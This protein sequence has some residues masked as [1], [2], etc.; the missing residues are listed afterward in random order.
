MADEPSTVLG[1]ERDILEQALELLRDRYHL[2]TEA[3]VFLELCGIS[4]INTSITNQRDA[5]T[6]LV[7]L[8]RSPGNRDSQAKQ[9]GNLVEHLRRAFFEPYEL[10]VEDTDATVNQII[11]TYKQVVLTLPTLADELPG[12]PTLDEIETIRGAIKKRWADARMA[13]AENDWTIAWE[14]GGKN[15]IFAFNDFK[16]LQTRLE[17][18]IARAEQKRQSAEQTRQVTELEQQVAVLKREVTE[19]D[20]AQQAQAK[21]ASRRAWVLMTLGAIIGLGLKVL[22]DY[23]MRS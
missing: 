17:T 2:A 8:L 20:T 12:A 10:A 18:Y 3:N 15:L 21:R 19:H 1:V 16:A 22:Y 5:V 11:E 7:S 23:V 13:K 9:L 14:S 4:G 6:H